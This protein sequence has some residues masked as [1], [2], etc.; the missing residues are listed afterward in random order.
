MAENEVLVR[1]EDLEPFVDELFRRA[2]LGADDAAFSARCL[3]NTNL[4]GVDSH[5][6]LR[7][8]DYVKRLRKRAINPQ[9]QTK[10]CLLYTSD[11]AD[12]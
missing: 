3:V 10:V 9:P 2:G 6:V 8:P 7:L 12:E 5:G 1:A 11:A 4:W